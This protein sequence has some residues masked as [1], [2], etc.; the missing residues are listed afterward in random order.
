[1]HIHDKEIVI[2]YLSKRADFK[3]AKIEDII[4]NLY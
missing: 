3:T 4:D 1:M 2:A